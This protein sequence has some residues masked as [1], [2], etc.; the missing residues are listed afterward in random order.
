MCRRTRGSPVGAGHNL[1]GVKLAYRTSR[2][3]PQCGGGCPKSGLV[4]DVQVAAVRHIDDA[5]PMRVNRALDG[6]DGIRQGDHV[7]VVLRQSDKLWRL[8]PKQ[9]GSPTRGRAPFCILAAAIAAKNENMNG[10]TGGRVQRHCAS[11]AQHFVE[12]VSGND[13]DRRC[14]H[15]ALMEGLRPRRIRLRCRPRS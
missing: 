15:V 5:R 12:G 10:R 1:V 14:A 11:A 2:D 6:A 8:R 13:E 9:G 3:G 4:V 7:A